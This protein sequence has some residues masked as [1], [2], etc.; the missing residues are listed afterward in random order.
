M[1]AIDRWK[2]TKAEFNAASK[3][4]WKNINDVKRKIC[5]QCGQDIFQYLDDQRSSGSGFVSRLPSLLLY[6]SCH[7]G[8]WTCSWG[9]YN[10]DKWE[11]MDESSHWNIPLKEISARRDRLLTI[12]P[13]RVE[14]DFAI[15]TNCQ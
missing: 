13:E 4:A 5:T 12:T 11:R 10:S 15:I 9:S 14:A 8:L 1:Y 6:E 7:S 3:T 2:K